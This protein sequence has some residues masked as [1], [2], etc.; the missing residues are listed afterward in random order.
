VAVQPERCDDA[1]AE[2]AVATVTAN[3]II[4]II[5]FIR[6]DLEVQIYLIY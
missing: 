6:S 5:F 3:T 2:N 1:Q 4:K